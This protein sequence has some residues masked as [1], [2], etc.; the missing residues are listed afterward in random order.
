MKS[1]LLL[2]A[3][4]AELSIANAMSYFLC[5]EM[6]KIVLEVYWRAKINKTKFKL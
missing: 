6:F 3:S 5:I 1:R 2:D 4:I